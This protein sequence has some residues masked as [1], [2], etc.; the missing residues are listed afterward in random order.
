MYEL[1]FREFA[2]NS[3]E[4][5]ST[6]SGRIL[7][8]ILYTNRWWCWYIDTKQ[9]V[10]E[11]CLVNFDKQSFMTVSGKCPSRGCSRAK[12]HKC[13]NLL[14][15]ER[16]IRLKSIQDDIYHIWWWK[17]S[18]SDWLS[19]LDAI[20]SWFLGWNTYGLNSRMNI[21]N[22]AFCFAMKAASLSR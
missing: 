2:P 15:L 18:R 16:K 11:Y 20:L 19:M 21:A 12:S 6:I 8:H 9:Y 7:W 3:K 4:M 1:Y 5:S 17:L 10:C 22:R 13:R 14:E